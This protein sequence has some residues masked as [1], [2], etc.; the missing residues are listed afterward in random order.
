ME[1]F[2]LSGGFAADE[3]NIVYQQHVHCAVT[4]S[5]LLS[6]VTFNG[7]DDLVCKV[8]TSHIK[9]V[10]IGV[11]YA[12]FIE[13]G[14]Q[15]MRFANTTRPVYKQRVIVARRVVCNRYAGGMSKFI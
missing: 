13:D 5:E 15:K 12:G 6:S 7:F 9:H 4:I 2:F 14:R 3:L 8:F 10:H 11:L 1:E